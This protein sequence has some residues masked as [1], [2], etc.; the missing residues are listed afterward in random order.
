LKNFKSHPIR[1]VLTISVGFMILSLTTQW[2]WLIYISLAVGIVG[3]FSNYLSKKIE[4]LWT[5]LAWLLS[6]IIPN[7]MLSIIFY[8][9]LFPLSL[10]SRLFGEKD[11]LSLK[12]KSNSLF[13]RRKI[14]FTKD[15]FENPW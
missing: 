2:G 13:K 1:T 5:K 10:V 4:F 8:L 14:P 15:S 7:I 9:I 11:P 6:L 3:I 12:N